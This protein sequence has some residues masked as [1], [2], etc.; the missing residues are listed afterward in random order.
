MTSDTLLLRQV[1]PHW[2]REGRVTSQAFKPTAKDQKKLSVYDGDQMT[3]QEAYRHYTQRLKLT[4]AGVIALT[5][6]E[7]RQ[8]ELPVTPDPE[9]FPEHVVIDFSDYSN[10]E[11]K[12]KAK[13]LT[14]AA[15]LRGWQY[16]MDPA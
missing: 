3:A 12:T 10:A 13:Y 7:C 1:N 5:V 6:V 2:I 16:R 15:M 8:Q 11:I 14:R 9:P 4:S